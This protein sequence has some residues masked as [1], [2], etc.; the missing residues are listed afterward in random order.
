[1]CIEVMTAKSPEVGD[2]GKFSMRCSAPWLA[3]A[4]RPAANEKPA[5]ATTA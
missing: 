4:R 3:L 2:E 5:L 1:M